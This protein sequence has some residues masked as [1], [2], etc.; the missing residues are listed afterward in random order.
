MFLCNRMLCGFYEH[1]PYACSLIHGHSKA[2]NLRGATKNYGNKKYYYFWV[3]KQCANTPSRG[4]WG[5]APPQENF[6]K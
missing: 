2:K 4:V 3:H 1:V 6:E 5:H